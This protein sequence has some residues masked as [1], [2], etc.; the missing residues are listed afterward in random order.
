[1]AKKTTSAVAASI[2][3]NLAPFARRVDD[4]AKLSPQAAEIAAFYRAVIPLLRATTQ[5][6]ERLELGASYI[7]AQ[8]VMERPILADADLPID[9]DLHTK[10]FVALC[11]VVENLTPPTPSASTETKANK[12]L[13][14]N[15]FKRGKPD[16]AQLMQHIAAGDE[17]SLRRAAATQIRL[18]VENGQLDLMAVFGTLL[19]G[20]QAAIAENANALKLDWQMLA[21]L[22]ENSLRP[23]FRAWANELS[24]IDTTGWHSGMC[25]ICGSLPIFSEIAGKESE[26]KLRCGMCGFGWRYPRLVCMSCGC[27]DH[28]QLGRISGEG[29]DAEKYFAQTCN[30]CKAYN[31]FI[32]NFDPLAVELLQVE[33]LL[34]GHFDVEARRLGYTSSKNQ[35]AF[36]V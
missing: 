8:L 10:L 29:M 34:C 13:F 2:D 12:S 31:K 28:H 22:A 5:H 36:D 27:D 24:D 32:A 15:L 25:P 18:A 23:A 19:T 9:I 30:R 6:I 14:S 21:M 17:S 33:D 3:P 20:N 1:M 7:Q 35:I 4:L 16:I 11:R 26:R